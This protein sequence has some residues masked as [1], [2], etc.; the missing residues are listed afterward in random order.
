MI[1]VAL[2][3][4]IEPIVDLEI[5]ETIGLLKALNC[6][7]EMQYNTDIELDCKR[8]VDGLYSKRTSTSDLSAILSDC[9]NLLA[10]NLV[11]SHVKE[12]KL[13]S[14]AILLLQTSYA[15]IVLLLLHL[16]WF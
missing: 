5:G 4:W 2:W 3:L 9:R 15:S 6:L 11:N 13:P 10:T 1:K 14:F 16:L 7:Y 8:V 12:Q